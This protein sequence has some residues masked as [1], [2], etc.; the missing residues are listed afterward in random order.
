MAVPG[1]LAAAAAACLLSPPPPTHASADASC[2][3]FVRPVC[4]H[5]WGKAYGPRRCRHHPPESPP[6]QCASAPTTLRKRGR[7]KHVRSLFERTS[8]P[9]R[10]SRVSPRCVS[11]SAVQTGRN[12]TQFAEAASCCIAEDGYTDIVSL[13]VCGK[14]W[15][16][17][18]TSLQLRVSPNARF[19]RTVLLMCAIYA[20]PSQTSSH[21]TCSTDGRSDHST[22]EVGGAHT[23][24]APCIAEVHLVADAT[25]YRS[26]VPL[27]DV[28]LHA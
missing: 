26:Q 3:L 12:R 1:W 8:R 20:L 15:P 14:L 4:L 23:R 9:P 21:Y 16:H 28:F 6:G 24:A 5:E 27:Q 11:H 17:G 22:A 2:T 10:L 7:S 25:S 19:Y 18:L 13:S